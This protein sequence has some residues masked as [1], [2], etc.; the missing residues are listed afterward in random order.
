[1]AAPYDH[2]PDA[3]REQSQLSGFVVNE[4]GA[5]NP[6]A[7]GKIGVAAMTPDRKIKFILSEYS[8]AASPARAALTTTSEV[9]L[10]AAPG[11]GLFVT[12]TDMTGSNDGATKSRLDL[13]EG[14]GGT[15]RYSYVM[16]AN[17]GGFAHGAL[18]TAWRL[19]ENTALVVQ[20]TAAGNSY[21][22]VNYRVG[23]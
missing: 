16:A 11:A 6:V 22:T 19:P 12:V 17:G 23:A 10:V 13:K 4:T 9:V 21:V 14:A 3:E 5:L 20:Q 2:T 8:G 15:V 1:M 7:E 18:G